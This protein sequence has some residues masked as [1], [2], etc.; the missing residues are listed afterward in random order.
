ML[1]RYLS[2]AM[3][4]FLFGSLIYA[5]DVQRT[6]GFARL[7]GMGNNPYVVD[8]YG[9]TV[10]PAWGSAYDNFLF[11]DLGSTAG[12][13]GSGGVGQFA[14]ANFR[15]NDQ[16]TLGGILSR[17]DFNGLAIAALDPLGVAGL[18]VVNTLN[19][20]P[21]VTLPAINLNNNFEL[22]GTF[23]FGN[24][25]LGLGVAYAA[26]TNEATP[27]GGSTTSSSASQ[28]GVNVG[29]LANLSGNFK[30]DVG[31]SL[32]MPSATHTPATGNESKVS[33]TII[34][35]NI[36]G[37]YKASQKV[38]LVPVIVFLNSSGTIDVGGATTTSF[39]MPS[40]MVI[41][42]G[43][44]INYK[45]GDFLLAGGPAFALTTF[46]TPEVANVS[47]ELKTSALSFP[48]WNLGAEWMLT[49]WLVGRLGYTAVTSKVTTE[50]AA[51]ATTIN[52]AV[53]T[54]FFGPNG[55]TVGVGFRLGDFSL[56]ATVNEDV[57]RQGLNNIGGGGATFAYLSASYAF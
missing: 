4:V 15:L 46:T 1:K 25:V 54:S 13:F 34:G 57:L 52:E 21:G 23:K 44:G 11:G 9:I 10:N 2:I 47:P 3:L 40:L 17:N 24:S 33:Q 14:S 50:T 45:I 27:A 20:L 49:E 32:G 5:Q 22:M 37:F 6:G 35:A 41:G 36:R 55:A 19:G 30:L 29:L 38:T 43:A 39:D 48:I 8:P 42:V 26:T 56:D 53:A 16:L 31:V 7:L 18:G 28:I 12:A 51:T